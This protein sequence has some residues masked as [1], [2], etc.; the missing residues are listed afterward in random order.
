MGGL[1][2]IGNAGMFS[3]GGGGTVIRI[4]SFGRG[5]TIVIG[6]VVPGSSSAFPVMPTSTG[7][8][9]LSFRA[10]ATG[11]WVDPPTSEGYRY[12]MANNSLFT[13]IVN[14]PTGFAQPFTVSVG[15]K[16]VGQFKPG[17]SVDFSKL[18]GGGV[19]EFT[20]TGITP[21]TDPDDPTAFPLQLAFNTE[22]AD[23]TMEAIQNTAAV[24]YFKNN[25]PPLEPFKITVVT[26]EGKVEV[27][28]ESTAKALT[29]QTAKL[30][31][32][33]SGLSESQVEK[34][35]AAVE[36]VKRDLNSMSSNFEGLFPDNAG[37]NINRLNPSMNSASSLRKSLAILLGELKALPKNRSTEQGVAIANMLQEIN[38]MTVLLEATSPVLKEVSQA[39]AVAK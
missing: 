31:S 26:P 21:L 23:F 17:D 9:R 32:A 22:K 3:L 1:R 29:E 34:L 38:K 12:V 6:A 11:A 15:G 18:P 19:K 39:V 33:Q 30:T 5:I 2:V 10:V 35:S 28:P 24:E 16:V 4:L 20:V 7:G 37:L 14:F 8:G 13:K 36:S 25:P 27:E